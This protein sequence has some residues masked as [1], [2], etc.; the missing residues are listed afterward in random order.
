[1]MRAPAAPHS[2]GAGAVLGADGGRPR[3]PQPAMFP[4]LVAA[5]KCA[6]SDGG[7]TAQPL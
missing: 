7:G 2:S 1:M 5:G 6:G 4:T 3:R